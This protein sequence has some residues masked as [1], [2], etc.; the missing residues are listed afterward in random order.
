MEKKKKNKERRPKNSELGNKRR[1]KGSK[2]EAEILKVSIHSN[3][4]RM[5]KRNVE[6]TSRAKMIGNRTWIKF[7]I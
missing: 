2:A 7:Q 5:N 4:G 3:S 1:K 6:A